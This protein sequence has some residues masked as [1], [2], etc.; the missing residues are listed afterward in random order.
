MKPIRPLLLHSCGTHSKFPKA[1]LQSGNIY[2]GYNLPHIYDLQGI[3][4]LKFLKF[5]LTIFDKTGRLMLTQI[6]YLQLEIGIGAPF[7]NSDYSTFG[8][9]ATSTWIKNI[10]EYLQKRDLQLDLSCSFTF[11]L[12]RQ[13]NI[14]ML[15][16]LHQHFPIEDLL[17]LN[18]VRLHLKVLFLSDICDIHGK[19]ILPQIKNGQTPRDSSFE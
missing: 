13:N 11:P 12:Q 9:F 14:F 16:V 3:Q 19:S 18:K 1:I 7:F 4:K 15:D 17:I 2:G 5:H 6:Q 8:A 10:W